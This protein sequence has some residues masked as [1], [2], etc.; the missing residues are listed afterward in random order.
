MALFKRNRDDERTPEVTV[1]GRKSITALSPEKRAA[2]LDAAKLARAEKSALL[3]KIRAGDVTLADVLGAA[4]EHNDRV[5][6]LQVATLLRALPGVTGTT[7]E[8][9]MLDAR[10]YKG[11]RI[12]GLTDRQR[13]ALLDWQA[14]L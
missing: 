11:R 8:K 12:Q 4:F 14:G 9:V 5:Q 1:Q 6:R 3:I 2:A 7:A 13:Q 10:I